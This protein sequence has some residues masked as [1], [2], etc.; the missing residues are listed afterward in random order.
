MS[1]TTG[2]PRS[3]QSIL[4]TLEDSG[5]TAGATAVRLM[6]AAADA[7]ADKGFHATTTRDIAS[8]AGLSPAGV[9][10]HFSS[11]ED[12]LFQLSRRGHQ[13]ARD[14]LVEAARA[15]GSPPEALR[16]IIAGFS[17][18]HAEHHQLGRIVQYEFRHLTPEHRDEVLALRR[19][20]DKVVRGVLKDGVE[21]GDF[22]VDD[23]PSTALALLSMAVDVARWY[24]PE[25]RR[26]P[27]DIAR[28][29]G[30]L[31]MRLVA[32]R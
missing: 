24:S 3:E 22:E 31:A 5:D 11:K 21:S 30:H 14:Q 29:N 13:T 17:R 7:F 4:A 25:I 9:Y 10:V 16:S 1:A 2:A 20:I 26:T 28:T 32:R 6:M 15:A 18:W 12:L 19:E 23:I 8:R 27:D